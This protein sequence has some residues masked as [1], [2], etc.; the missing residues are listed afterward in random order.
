MLRMLR[1]CG[2]ILAIRV[3]CSYVLALAAERALLFYT[4]PSSPSA[5]TA[6]RSFLF[7]ALPI[8]S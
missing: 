6:S 3:N 2:W 7:L 4:L 8:L 5:Y 1:L